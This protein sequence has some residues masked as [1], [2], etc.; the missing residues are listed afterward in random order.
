MALQVGWSHTNAAQSP[1]PKDLNK[2]ASDQIN[3][4]H[5]KSGG[6]ECIDAIK[7]Q[8]TPEE[9]RGYLRG[10]VCKYLWRMDNKGDPCINLQKANWY[11]D[12]LM[13]EL[14]Q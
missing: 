11:I 9:F 4:D 5:Y 13:Q 6:I 12:R 14:A 3:P 1:A 2:M 8:M 10:N 7:A